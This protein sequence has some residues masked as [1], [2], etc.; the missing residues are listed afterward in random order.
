MKTMISLTVA[1][2]LVL[3]V[4][5]AIAGDTFRALSTMPAGEQ[6][7]LTPLSDEQLATIEGAAFK[8]HDRHGK[9][10][11]DVGVNI[12]DIDQTNLNIGGFAYQSNLAV[13]GQSNR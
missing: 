6:T 4:V 3:S 8:K 2:A 13:V 9:C 5:P 12:A 11:G 10:C 1:L 7:L